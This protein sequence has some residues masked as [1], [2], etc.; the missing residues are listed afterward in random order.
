MNGMKV[1]AFN[2]P[3]CGAAFN[4]EKHKCDYCGSFIF[5]EDDKQFDVSENIIR[6]ISNSQNSDVYVNGNLIGKGEIPLR[7]GLATYYPKFPF[8]YSNGK[9]TLTEKNLYFTSPKII[10]VQDEASFKI[11]L[12]DVKDVTT[13]LNLIVSQHILIHTDTQ[14][15][16]FDV[17]GGNEW[18]RKIKNAAL[19]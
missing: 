19:I 3:N 1:T 2:C 12:S 6:E 9:L 16:R 13:A 15:F 14:K 5:L 11:P 7:I 4:P 8:S 10:L 17:Y 18:I